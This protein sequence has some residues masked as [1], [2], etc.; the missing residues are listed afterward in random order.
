MG[1]A[2]GRMHLKFARQ[3]HLA[4]TFQIDGPRTAKPHLQSTAERTSHSR[5][6]PC[7]IVM[8]P[9]YRLLTLP[10]FR[11]PKRH[12]GRD[13]AACCLRAPEAWTCRLQGLK[14]VTDRQGGTREPPPLT[15]QESLTR[16]LR[17]G[18]IAHFDTKKFGAHPDRPNLPGLLLLAPQ[19]AA[20]S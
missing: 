5:K 7:R 2:L 3:S 12:S 10:R 19:L 16:A 20:S 9:R 13:R 14:A 6:K 1:M 4:A 11:H 18:H 8:P 15:M 17:R